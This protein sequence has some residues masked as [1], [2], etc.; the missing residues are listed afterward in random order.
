MTEINGHSVDHHFKASM[1]IALLQEVIDEHGDV[2]VVMAKDPE[3]NGYS[4]FAGMDV[5]YYV[6]ECTWSGHYGCLEYCRKYPDDYETDP[7][8][9][10][11]AVCLGPVN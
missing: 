6:P 3:G 11:K 7:E 2:D 9:A 1:L 10:V 5:G 8:F 4:P